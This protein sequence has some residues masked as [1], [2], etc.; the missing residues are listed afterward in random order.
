MGL[1]AQALVAAFCHG[2]AGSAGK[3]H[4][5]RA[6]EEP[7]PKASSSGQAATK[8]QLHGKA[9]GSPLL[10]WRPLPGER[11]GDESSQVQS[12]QLQRAPEPVLACA[13]CHIPGEEA[14]KCDLLQK[15]TQVIT[16][17][18]GSSVGSSWVTLGCLPGVLATQRGL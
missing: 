6:A 11:G 17:L 4:G 2:A 5:R 1:P 15:S 3:P 10:L 14:G 9:P 12:R 18:L 13:G 16:Y 8:L 7:I